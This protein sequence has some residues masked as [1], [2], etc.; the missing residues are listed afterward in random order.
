ATAR[1]T[2]LPHHG[3]TARGPGGPGLE[4]GAA[5]GL[6]APPCPRGGARQS[7]LGLPHGEA[8][9]R[10]RAGPRDGR[11]AGTAPLRAGRAVHGPPPPPDLPAVRPHRGSRRVPHRAGR[12]GPSP[13]PR[14]AVAP[15]QRHRARAALLRGLP[16]LQRRRLT[17]PSPP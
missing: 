8:S 14:S 10:R 15:V 7:R 4:P 17:A 2:G 9:L 1:T 12:P 11:R 5:D 13:A 6:A 16:A 3:A